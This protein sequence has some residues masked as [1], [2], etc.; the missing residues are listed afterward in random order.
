ME[1]TLVLLKP[2]AVKRGIIGDVISRFEK[3]GLKI[4][5]VKMVYP[6]EAHYHHHYEG[7]SKL[8]T[9]VGEDVFKKNTEFMLS[10]PVIAIVLEAPDAVSKVR[11]LVGQTDPAA[12]EQG[13]IRGD[14]GQMT[15]EEAN[16]KN[17]ALQNIVHASG[18]QTEAQQE[19]EHWFKPAE[20]FD[21]KLTHE[22]TTLSSEN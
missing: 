22:N 13:T 5:G 2:D 1:K 8:K 18:D 21:Y 15:L 10:G 17:I 3:A 6:D 16:Q 11:K 7:I 20:L 14:W 19:V 9:R 12:A 4:L